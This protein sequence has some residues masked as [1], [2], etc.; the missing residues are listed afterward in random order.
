[1]FTAATKNFGVWKESRGSTRRS[2]LIF[3]NQFLYCLGFSAFLVFLT[4]IL[5]VKI[6]QEFFFIESSPITIFKNSKLNANYLLPE[7]ASAMS[8][9]LKKTSEGSLKLYFDKG[10]RFVLPEESDEFLTYLKERKKTIVYLGMLMRM[11]GDQNSRVKILTDKNIHF[12]DLRSIMNIFAQL[13]F[14]SFDIG[15]ER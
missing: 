10:E 2:F 13:G 12:K 1:M 7:R 11:N 9:Y 6:R 14:D 15:V 5:C 8:I 4:L 3:Q